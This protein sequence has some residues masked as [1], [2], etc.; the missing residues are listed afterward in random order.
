MAGKTRLR[1][2]FFIILGVLAACIIIISVCCRDSRVDTGDVKETGSDQKI[3][4]SILCCG[5]LV[6]HE[7]VLEAAKTD[8]GYDFTKSFRYIEPYIKKADL[9]FCSLEAPLVSGGYSGYP[10]FRS[11]DDLATSLGDVGFDMA[12]TSSNHTF[13]AG[14]D[15][16]FRTLKV[17]KKAGLKVAGSREKEDEPR[18]SMF[19]KDGVKVA[20]VSYVYGNGDRNSRDLN[21]NV[22]TENG[23]KLINTFGYDTFDEDLK[24]IKSTVTAA[25]DAGAGIVIMY[26][27]WGDEYI[28]HSNAQQRSIAKKT[29]AGTDVDIIVGSHPHV[30]QER[31]ETEGTTVYY[32]MGNLLSNQRREY[33]DGDV[34]PEEGVMIKLDAVYDKDKDELVSLK[35]TAIPYWED[36]NGNGTG[37]YTLIPL[38]GDYK[39]NAELKKSGHVKYA[40]QAKKNI[41]EILKGEQ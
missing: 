39:N 17:L 26:Y 31:A 11:P 20:V 6:M 37:K 10:V 40:V 25:R 34:H 5:D 12:L 9:S 23:R 24:Q 27:H 1:P 38:T 41:E 30:V 18:Y 16:M 19:E 36:M 7:A 32:A 15:G 29:A 4:V 28:T 22:L 3:N 35:D 8:N 14:E 21:G 33:M 2:R 13:D